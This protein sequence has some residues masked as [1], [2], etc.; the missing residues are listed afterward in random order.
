MNYPLVARLLGALCW[1]MGITMLFSIPWAFPVMGVAPEFER[2]GC[3][4]LLASM[5]VCFAVGVLLRWLGRD[6]QM[7]LFRKE[8]MAVVGLSWV[9]ATVLG[10]L[11]YWLSGTCR[12]RQEADKATPVRMTV[13]DC[14]FESQSGFST[15]GA[16]VITD[17]EDTKLVPRSIL[18]WRSSTHFLGGLGIIVLFVAV[19][20]QGSAG[21]ALMR[22]EIPGPSKEG[23]QERMQH[24]AWNFAAIYVALNLILTVLL[25]LESKKMNLFNALCHAFGTMATGGF[26]T[27]NDSVAAFDSAL[28]DYTITVF[29]IIA[30]MNFTLI[31]LVLVG[32]WSAMWKDIEWRAYLTGMAVVI[33][34]IMAMSIGTY[35]EFDPN[36]K[37]PWLTEFRVAFRYVS[38]QVVSIMTTT[39]FGTHNFDTWHQ[40]ARALLFLLMFVGGCAGS[41]GGGIKVIRHVLFV[42]ILGM[43]IERSY[44]PTVVRPL[45]LG[46]NVTT[47]AELRSQIL[48]YFGLV[49]FI[50]M[51]SWITLVA[52]EPESTWTEVGQPVDNKLID[53]ASAVAATMNNIGPGLGTVGA[54]Q[55]YANFE[56][57]SKLL[58]IFL[59]TLG[60]LELFAVLVLLLP[61]FW[62]S[63]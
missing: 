49:T 1:L 61:G 14:L 40:L 2:S 22:A 63:H 6:A 5:V 37:L 45:K 34:A 39:G 13:Y 53:C 27:Y 57:L 46:D 51:L 48:L 20:G 33:A 55:N 52:I 15:T 11:P 21:K 4:A 16:T 17:L 25:M 43:E 18:F 29:M 31:Y 47:D 32:R 28:V 50:F 35:H 3:F 62:R 23:S 41:T 24:T 58:F 19:L 9:L 30:G 44:H 36:D 38:F 8:A 56:P 60:R 7:N 10:A 54:K 42:K 59:M 12:G 26:S